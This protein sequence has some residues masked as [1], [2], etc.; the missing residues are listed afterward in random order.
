MSLSRP[1][2][3]AAFCEEA[4][5]GFSYIPNS[6]IDTIRG[7][8]DRVINTLSFSEMS[9]YQLAYYARKY[10]HCSMTECC[11][12]KTKITSISDFLAFKRLSQFFSCPEPLVTKDAWRISQGRANLW[13]NRPILP[14]L[15][16]K[17]C[18]RGY[19]R[20]QVSWLYKRVCRHVCSRSKLICVSRKK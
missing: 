12:N 13:S 5:Y 9:V 8:F 11:S 3:K 7:K 18:T 4:P 19:F 6:Q 10:P 17:N 1:D 15:G 16:F 2:I 14:R 20:N